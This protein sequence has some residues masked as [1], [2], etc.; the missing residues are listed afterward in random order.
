MEWSSTCLNGLVRFLHG[1]KTLP[2]VKNGHVIVGKTWVDIPFPRSIPGTWNSHKWCFDWMIPNH[3]K[4]KMGGVTI[5]IHLKVACLGFQVL[6]TN[7]G[8]FLGD[9][10]QTPFCLTSKC[11]VLAPFI[12]TR[13]WPPCTAWHFLGSN[14]W[15]PEGQLGPKRPTTLATH[16]VSRGGSHPKSVLPKNKP[17]WSFNIWYLFILKN[18]DWMYVFLSFQKNGAICFCKKNSVFYCWHWNG[19]FVPSPKHKKNRNPSPVGLVAGVR[20]WMSRGAKAMTFVI[21]KRS[22]LRS[23]SW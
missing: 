10:S 20:W 13:G 7:V 15:K 17:R 16:D 9:L 5:S 3:D 18:M 1:W 12:T 14:F 21:G 19:F 2:I 11:R 22:A 6:R 4:W 23:E 8:I